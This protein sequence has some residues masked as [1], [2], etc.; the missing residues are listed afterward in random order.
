MGRNRTELIMGLGRNVKKIFW[1]TLCAIAR[2]SFKDFWREKLLIWNESFG[3]FLGCA[4]PG[5]IFCRSS[6]E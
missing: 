2:L 4:M 1:T 5:V 6:A 3:Q